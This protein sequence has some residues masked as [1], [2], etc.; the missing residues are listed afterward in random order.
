MLWL[1]ALQILKFTRENN[2][3]D[4]VLPTVRGKAAS[5]VS[6][7]KLTK[8]ESR[9]LYLEMASML[10]VGLDLKCGGRDSDEW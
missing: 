5:F 4:E 9:A 6:E 3:V 8:E 2:L 10:E 7:W 1:C